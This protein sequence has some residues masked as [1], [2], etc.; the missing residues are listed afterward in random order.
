MTHLTRVTSRLSQTLSHVLR[1]TVWVKKVTPIPHPKNLQYFYSRWTCVIENFV[2]CFPTVRLYVSSDCVP[3]NYIFDFKI[4]VQFITKFTNFFVK[5]TNPINDIMLNTLCLKSDLWNILLPRC[6][7][8]RRGLAMRILS[9]C[10]S[11]CLS[12]ACIVTKR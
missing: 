8:C 7:Q 1:P 12:H 4:S 5:T 10:L 3:I 6:M 2:R 9:V 11:V